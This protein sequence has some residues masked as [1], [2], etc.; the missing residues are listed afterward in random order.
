MAAGGDENV[1]AIRRDGHVH[2]AAAW[3]SPDTQTSIGR[4][5]QEFQK[6]GLEAH[7]I[8]A[9]EGGLG[10]PMVDRL[11]ELGWQVNRVNFGAKPFDPGY[12]NRGAEMWYETA[13]AMAR[14]EMTIGPD[15]ELIAQLTTRKGKPLGN[16]KL[17]L[18]SKADL[19]SRGGTSPDRAD[20][21]CGAWTC[22]S[23]VGRRQSLFD[24]WQEPRNWKTPLHL[25][26]RQANAVSQA[27]WDLAEGRRLSLW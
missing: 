24:A 1:L 21:V 12:E 10:R 4:F 5:V 23:H 27:G 16:G 25:E 2:I 15:D 20:A 18:E 9:D 14:R 3:R 7:E 6:A 17:G 8:F 26:C 22:R 11:W 19:K 13:A